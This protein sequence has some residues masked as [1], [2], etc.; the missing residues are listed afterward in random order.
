MNNEEKILKLF[1]NGI[2]KTNT[3]I[4]NNI[5]KIYLTRMIKNGKIERIGR[6]LYIKKSDIADEFVILQAR[7]TKA[8]F[9]NM[10]SLYLHGLSNRIPI[11]YDITVPIGYNGSLQKKENVN[12][13]YCK[14][15]LLKLGV[16]QHKLDS[17]NIIKIYD[18]ERTICDIIR[19]KKKLDSELFNKAIRDY[20]YGKNK[21]N[22]KLHEYA[23]KLNIEKKVN[24][25]F[26]VLK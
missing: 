24:D 14:R 15:E 4:E 13:Y 2:L 22:L 5:S 1:K 9:S 7:S 12:L 16:M 8:I 10:T 25:T 18:L 6:G 21:D 3:L 23:K 26:E 11:D 17:G 20:F 19:N